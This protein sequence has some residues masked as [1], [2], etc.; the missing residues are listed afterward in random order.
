[1][2]T[3]MS[4]AE[5]AASQPQPPKPRWQPITAIDRRV[6]GALVEKAKTTPEAYPMTLNAITTACNQ[7]NNRAP[8]MQLEPDQVNEALERLRGLGAVGLIEG[9]GRVDKYRH[10]LYDWLGVD[11][12]ELAVMAELL[13]RGDQTEGELRGRASRMEPIRDLG[14]LRPVLESLTAK[15]LLISLTP[16]GRGHAVT[17]ALYRP[18]EL[19]R[20]KADYAGR[21]AP[22]ASDVPRAASEPTTS[23]LDHDLSAE[24]AALRAEVADLRQ[25]LG[26]LRTQFERFTADF[27]ALAADFSR[28]KTDLGA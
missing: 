28:V 6:L 5:P 16:E 17:H 20:L 25:Q 21:P 1:M 24:L 26:E 12:V 13:L 4:Q 11:K 23:A 19:E 7:K 3:A 2:E 9:Q 27:G 14:A 22:V 15:G 10:Y 18:Q 8:V